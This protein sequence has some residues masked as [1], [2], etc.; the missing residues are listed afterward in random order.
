MATLTR[1][2]TLGLL[3][4][5]A[6][7]SFARRGLG[8][9]AP[10]PN[11]IFIMT[12]DQRQDAMSAYGNPI[13]KTPNMDRIGAE[14]IRFSEA[15]VTNSLCAPSRASFLTGLYSHAHGIWTNGDGP[16]FYNGPGLRPDQPTFV[17][18]LHDAGYH[19]GLVGK[20]HLKSA[21]AGFDEW[22]IFP[23]Q[24][25]YRDPEMIAKGVPL[26]MRGH[27]DDVVGDQAIEFLRRRPRTKPICLLYQFKSPHRT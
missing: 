8:Q 5:A 13:L 20:W 24:G 14:G 16:Q 21:P 12:D 19:T 17:D 22:V 7:L 9:D 2:S 10:P 25:D 27:A 4:S 15:F 1:R 3:G 11:M 6:A 23:W 18:R 26:R